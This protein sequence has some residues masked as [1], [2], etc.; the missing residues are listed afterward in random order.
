MGGFSLGIGCSAER[1][2]QRTTHDGPFPATDLIADGSACRTADRTTNGGIQ[3]RVVGVC[4]G[5]H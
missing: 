5:C 4:L 1:R 3:C 2:T